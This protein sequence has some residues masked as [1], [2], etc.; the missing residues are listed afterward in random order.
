MLVASLTV[1]GALSVQGI[2]PDDADSDGVPD[3]VDVCPGEDASRFDRDGDGCIDDFIGARHVE[4]WGVEDAT[5]T[6][7]I[8]DIA[9]PNISNGTDITAIQNAVSAWTGIADTELNVVYGGT[10]SQTNAD[11]LDRVNLVTFVDNTYPFSSLVLAVG[12]STSFESDTLIAGRV[13]RQ[14]EIYDTDMIFN[15]SKTFKTSGSVGVD[16]QSVAT[17]EAGHL[18][19]IS[20]STV[21]SSTMF[22]ALPGGNAAR[23]LESDDELVFFKAYGSESELAGANRIEGTV[24][25]G[26]SADPVGGAIVF[27]IDSATGDTTGCDYTLPD[28]SF[29]FPGLPNGSYYVSIHPL[30]GS[31]L[32]GYIEPGNI[33]TFVEDIAVTH[34]M[35]ESY[36]AAESSLDDPSARTALTVS[37]GSVASADIITNIDSTAPMVLDTTPD[38][39]ATGMSVDGAYVIEFSEPLDINTVVASFTFRD[40]VTALPQ[41]GFISIIRDDSVLVFLPSPTLEFERGYTLTIDTDLKDKAGNPL[42]GDFTLSVTTETEPALSISSLLP[43]KGIVGNTVVISGQGFSTDPI[44]TVMFGSETATVVSGTN[45]KLVV[46]VPANAVTGA[47]SVTNPDLSVSNALTFTVLTAAEVARGFDSGQAVFS[48]APNAVTIVPSGDYA[49]AATNSGAE[50]AVVSPALAEYL[51]STPIGYPHP[52]TDIAATPTGTRVYAVSEESGELVEIVSDPTTGPVFNTVLSSRALGA[53]PKGIVVDPAGDR[54]YIATDESDIQVWDIRLGSLTY[55]Q[56][57]GSLASPGGAGLGGAMAVTPDGA[58]LLAV[59]EGGDLVAFD[60]S[61]PPENVISFPPPGPPP[62]FLVTAEPPVVVSVGDAPHGV[63]VDPQGERAYVSHDDGDISVVNIQGAAFEVQDIA[64][65]GSLRGLS[66]TPGGAYLYAADRVLDNVKIIDLDITHATFRSVVEDI[67]APGNPVDVVISPDGLYAFTVLQGSVQPFLDPKLLVTTIGLGPEVHCIYP[68]AGTVGTKVLISGNELGHAEDFDEITVDFNGI[69]VPAELPDHVNVVATVPNGATSGPVRV[70]VKINGET[71]THASNSVPFQVLPNFAIIGRLR[72]AASIPGP[73]QANGLEPCIA[74]R[75]QGDLILVGNDGGASVR[76]IDI[77]PGSPDFHQEIFAL[78]PF[79]SGI[80]DVAITA[81]GKVAFMASGDDG[82]NRIPAMSCDPN[83]PS[84]GDILSYVGDGQTFATPQMVETSPD[85]QWLA[86]Y[87]N[88]LDEV[89]LIDAVGVSTGSI[90]AVVASVDQVTAFVTDMAFHPNARYL[91]I[92]RNNPNSIQVVDMNENGATFGIVQAV[93]PMPG[94]DPTETPFS[95]AVARNGNSVDVLSHALQSGP[96]T[97]S[98]YRFPLSADGLT[99]GTGFRYALSNGNFGGDYIE[100]L[101]VTPNNL[102]GVTAS[103]ADAIRAHDTSDP[104]KTINQLGVFDS[105]TESEFEFSP[106]GSRL[107]YVSTFADTVRVFD[108]YGATTTLY[109]LAVPS[110]NNQN[111]V[112][113]QVLPAPIRATTIGE[114]LPLTGLIMTFRVVSGGGGLMTPDGPVDEINVAT[115]EDGFAEVEWMLGPIVGEQLVEVIAEGIDQ[116]PRAVFANASADPN[117]LPLAIA[118]VLPL[119]TSSNVSATT[120]VL[121]TF[122]RAVDPLSIGSGSLFIEVVADATKIPVTFGF[123]DGGRK[124]SLTPSAP[125]EYSEGFRVVYAADIEDMNGGALSNPGS[126]SF[127][128]QAAPPPALDS[129]SPPS[130]LPGVSIVLNGAGF[131]P[132]PANNSVLFNNVAAVPTGGT[133]ARLDVVVPPG[134]TTGTVAVNAGSATSN[135]KPFT[136][137]QPN[138]SP[139]DEVIANV[140]TGSGPKTCAVTPD[141]ALCYTVSPDGDVVVPVDVEGQTAYAS[142]AVGDQ[143]VAIVMHPNGKFAYVA[144]FNAGTVSVI[145]VQPASSDFNRVVTTIEVGVNPVDLAVLPDGSRVLVANAGAGDVS[146]IDGNESSES[147]HD[148]VANVG[149][150][151]G[152]KS[153]AVSADGARI[154]IG[155]DT[156]FIVLAASGYA[157]VANVGTGTGA[158]SLAVSADGTLLFI[159]G[160]NGNILIVDVVPGSSSENDVVANVGTGTGAKS[161]A[162]SAD[163]A[164]LYVLQEGSDEVLVFAINVIPGVSVTDPDAAA[165]SFRVE[166]SFVKAVPVGADPSFVAVDPSGSGAVFVT[167]EGDKTL[168]ILDHNLP[169]LEARFEVFP[170]ILI[171]KL[172][173]PYVTGWVQLPDG[174]AVRDIDVSTVRLNGTVPALTNKV[175]YCDLNFDHV[176]DVL[177]IFKK[178]DLIATLEPGKLLQTVTITGNVGDRTFTGEDWLLALFPHVGNSSSQ[179]V[180]IP[181]EPNRIWWET[182]EGHQVEAADVHVSYDNGESWDPIAINVPNTGEIMWLPPKDAMFRYGGLVMVTLYEQGEVL[183]QGVSAEP[184]AV[185]RP[186]QATQLKSFDAAVV[187]GAAVLRWE[188]IVEA[189]MDGFRVVRADFDD[190]TYAPVATQLVPAAGQAEGASYEYRDESVR[191]NRTYW[192]KLQEVKEDGLGREFGPYSLIYRLANG[193]EQNVPNPF[194]PTTSIKYSIAGDADVRLVIYDVAGREVRTLVDQHQ[195]ANVYRIVWDGINDQGDRVASGVYFYKLVAGT[196]T[197]TRKMMLLK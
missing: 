121:T 35:P 29:T 118:E 27:V 132:V 101:R 195:R 70:L 139:I 111:G 14:G 134:A 11:G 178:A 56:Q 135:T 125:L 127:T 39:D 99:F 174:F 176:E 96:A 172:K 8:N 65:G 92:A 20:H 36:D 185:A 116:S 114:G 52:L 117:T 41:S 25:E 124:V 140:G 2:I 88:S 146:V 141:G 130:A 59:T 78:K 107:Y 154:Y 106:D 183:I 62:F 49:Y 142:I 71:V 194:N 73:S 126:S 153:L 103:R 105:L 68:Q 95:L 15:P 3:S 164:L 33:N 187:D 58:L 10:T 158:K 171:V 79:G 169:P 42:A 104:S 184:F 44:P 48:Q 113:N 13:W 190:G 90:P 82:D 156:G 32:I 167:N 23:S 75:P 61:A 186:E 89:L 57:V 21:Q 149:T 18:W 181:G 173:N 148:V 197:S 63:A 54:A 136:V 80:A 162:V 179:N 28:G 180:V 22:Y 150:G 84:F 6:Y 120:A 170:P 93:Y 166:T 165:P 129:I 26:G 76:A 155:T 182:P 157:V 151:S 91:Y 37:G 102:I 53:A 147:H 152:A 83:S 17:H 160:T 144:N 72:Q 12:L 188:T 45:A 163:G 86:M 177:Y 159:L 192:Y 189:G 161:L 4:Y 123:T 46:T 74:V 19:G 34:F 145:D 94:A 47:V 67:E 66:V 9:A 81:D 133:T 16:I 38:D 43:S 55:Q 131:D 5:I 128:T 51:T 69:V 87:D 7:V 24:Q 60:I 110:G 40:D 168:S 119:N 175:I 109:Y 193:L 1:A 108:F 137:L 196:F 85:N 122:S 97:R 98:V 191:P 143:P 100:R 30:N 64:T 112:V 50:A 31:S 138:T 115:D 77:R